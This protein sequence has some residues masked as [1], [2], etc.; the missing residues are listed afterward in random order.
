MFWLV[1]GISLLGWVI[2]DLI[3]CKVWSYRLIE[4]KV[5]PLQYWLWT[6]IWLIIAIACFLSPFIWW[7]L[8]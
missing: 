3:T 1:I 4:R 2:I 6:M 8:L 7:N 5:E